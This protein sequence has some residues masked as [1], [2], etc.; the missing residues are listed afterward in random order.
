VAR[1]SLTGASDTPIRIELIASNGEV[2]M[3]L[4]DGIQP[5]GYYYQRLSGLGLPSGT[6]FVRMTAGNYERLRKVV[7]MK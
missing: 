4:V 6:Y 2:I 5:P 3:T 1:D 7:L